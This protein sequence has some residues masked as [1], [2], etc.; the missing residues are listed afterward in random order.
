[1]P[2]EV[3]HTPQSPRVLR[4]PGFALK[5]FFKGDIDMD[6]D[7]DVVMTEGP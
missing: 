2:S 6:I 3:S 5:G 7:V 4:A 1:M